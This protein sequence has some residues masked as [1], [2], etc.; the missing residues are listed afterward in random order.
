MHYKS[1]KKVLFL[2]IVTIAKLIIEQ[3][4]FHLHNYNIKCLI[5]VLPRNF[6]DSSFEYPLSFI[7][8]II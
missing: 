8:E 6:S 3:S 5:V 4:S 7:R 1:T 2:R